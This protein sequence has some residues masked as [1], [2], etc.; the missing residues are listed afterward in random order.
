LAQLAYALFGRA[1][2]VVLLVVLLVV[3]AGARI[4]NLPVPRLGGVL[5]A[6]FFLGL[7]FPQLL[8]GLQ[9]ARIGQRQQLADRL[10]KLER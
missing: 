4:E 6:L 10:V 9:F 2:L 1:T 3:R 7:D 5:R 8:P